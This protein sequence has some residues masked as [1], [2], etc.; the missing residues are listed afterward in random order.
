MVLEGS[1]LQLSRVDKATFHQGRDDWPLYSGLDDEEVAALILEYV[2]D[3]ERYDRE[4]PMEDPEQKWP[5]REVTKEQRADLLAR[6]QE[7]R[8]FLDGW[9]P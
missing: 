5:E 3:M 4:H 1:T 2:P 6:A 7:L 9:K 8:A